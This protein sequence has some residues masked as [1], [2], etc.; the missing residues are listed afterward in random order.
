MVKYPI[1]VIVFSITVLSNLQSQNIDIQ[2]PP[3]HNYIYVN[4][5]PRNV[6]GSP[7]LNDWQLSDIFLENG[8]TIS[9][10]MVRY[11][12]FT[13]QMLYQDKNTAYV[14]GSPDSISEIKVSGK[15]FEYKQYTEGKKS[16][17]GFF[18]TIVKGKVGLLNKY[19]IKIIASNYNIALD[20]GNK[21]DRLVIKEQLYL[22]QGG[23]IV[24]LNKKSV[25]SEVFKDKFKEVSDYMSNEELSYKK[26]QD[27]IKIVTFYNQLN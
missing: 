20:V 24:I 3:G 7:Y 13:D 12:V 17:K 18:E 15:I 27:M 5:F 14:I 9:D 16:E 6:E 19:E 1:L 10:I 25:L 23:Q 22:Q 21:N 2:A 8:E 4:D 11:N 26:K